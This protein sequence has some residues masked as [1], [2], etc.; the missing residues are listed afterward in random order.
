MK[1]LFISFFLL[2]FIINAT[3]QDRVV[4]GT[5]I[6]PEDGLPV[7]GAS[8][9]IKGT[10]IEA[11]TDADG[12]F[13]LTGVPGNAQRLQ[14]RSMGMETRS[15]QIKPEEMIIKLHKGEKAF[16]PFVQAGVVLSTMSGSKDDHSEHGTLI[17][18]FT[19]G[20][21]FSYSITPN[22]SL[23]PSINIVRKGAKWEG[24][25]YD[26]FK[27]DIKPI[28]LTLPVLGELKFWTGNTSRLLINFGPYIAYGIGGKYEIEDIS[29]NPF[30]KNDGES[31]LLKRFDAGLQYG[32]GWQKKHFHLSFNCA[33]G[34]VNILDNEIF[35]DYK[36]NNVTMDLSV[37]YRF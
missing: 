1:K 30:K 9:T 32:V 12:R 8:V 3:A 17:P 16:S 29:E 27:L 34:F 21:G 35:E 18:G 24:A 26:K 22:F 28:Y 15:A 14:V 13:T 23:T 20:V 10:N 25:G 33:V 36:M 31:A 19:A 7:V 6:C 5:V 37:G 11:M 2:L 4:K